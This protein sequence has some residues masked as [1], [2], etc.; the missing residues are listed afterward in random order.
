MQHDAALPAQ[1]RERAGLA[2]VGVARSKNEHALVAKACGLLRRGVGA[3]RAGLR[4]ARGIVLQR[5][6]PRE[7]LPRLRGRVLR[8][9]RHRKLTP[10]AGATADHFRRKAL[11]GGGVVLVF[12]RDRPIR[13]P[14]GRRIGHVAREACARAHERE[15]GIDHFLL[16]LAREA[17]VAELTDDGGEIRL[18]RVAIRLVHRHAVGNLAAPVEKR[19]VRG[20]LKAHDGPRVSDADRF[21]R[22]VRRTAAVAR[23]QRHVVDAGLRECVL[24]LCTLCRL[25]HARD[26]PGKS[27]RVAVRIGRARRI[28]RE[29]E[30]LHARRVIRRDLRDGR[31]VPAAIDDAHDAAVRVLPPLV[32]VLDQVERAVRAELHVNRP[33]QR[34]RGHERLQLRPRRAEFHGLDPVAHPLVNEEPTVERLGQLDRRRICRVEMIHRPRHDRAPAAADRRESLRRHARKPHKRGLRRRQFSNPR[35]AR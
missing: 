6:H 4:H 16:A 14:G 26:A 7:H 8:M 19:S 12:Q 32:A 23:G 18:H 2:I 15:S 5:E 13:R 28:E 21:L 25:L 29:R 34:H 35:V 24:E 27:Q 17:S 33:A 1:P 31:A 11:G 20:R 30:R 9:R 3:A 22:R 10:H